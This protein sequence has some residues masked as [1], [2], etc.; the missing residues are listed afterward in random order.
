MAPRDGDVDAFE[1]LLT[2]PCRISATFKKIGFYRT[3][4]R[5]YNRF[6]IQDEANL[7]VQINK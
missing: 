6:S 4:S 3:Y 2:Q 1:L 7:N 5:F